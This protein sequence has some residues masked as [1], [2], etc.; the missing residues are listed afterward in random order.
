MNDIKRGILKATGPVTTFSYFQRSGP[1]LFRHNIAQEQY[2]QATTDLEQLGIGTVVFFEFPS[3]NKPLF[4]KNSPPNIANIWE[5]DTTL[6]SLCSLQEY[7]ENFHM[8]MPV[9]ISKSMRQYLLRNGHISDEQMEKFYAER[10]RKKPTFV[11]K[12]P[13]KRWRWCRFITFVKKLCCF[14]FIFISVKCVC[15]H[16][17]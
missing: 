7:S 3:G 10:Q 17:D 15:V 9:T 2:D 13:L 8:A 4:V 1:R 6:E 12:R 14:V 11:K 16:Q 5:C